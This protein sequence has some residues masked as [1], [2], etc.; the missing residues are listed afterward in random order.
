MFYFFENFSFD[1]RSLGYTE[2]KVRDEYVMYRLKDNSKVDKYSVEYFN[3][4]SNIDFR[5]SLKGM[6]L[7]NIYNLTREQTLKLIPIF[8]DSGAFRIKDLLSYLEKEQITQEDFAKYLPQLQKLL[9]SQCIDEGKKFE[10]FGDPVTEE[11]LKMYLEKG[12][13]DKNTARELYEILKKKAEKNKQG[14]K[15]KSDTHSS[16]AEEKSTHLA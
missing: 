3:I 5:L 4:F 8:I 10:R 9:K 16:L 15:I 13:I 14:Q 7:V 11:E 6:D 12:Y 1:I 2:K